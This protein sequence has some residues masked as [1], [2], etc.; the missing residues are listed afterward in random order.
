MVGTATVAGGDLGAPV[1]LGGL[2]AC[3]NGGKTTVPSRR[4]FVI[5]NEDAEVGFLPFDSSAQQA[6]VTAAFY[7]CDGR[8]V[9]RSELCDFSFIYAAPPTFGLDG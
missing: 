7:A 9:A 3:I 5:L 6:A 1:Q 4:A 8:R 2:V